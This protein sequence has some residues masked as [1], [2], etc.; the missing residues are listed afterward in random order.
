MLIET[1]PNPSSDLPYLIAEP[2]PVRDAFC[3]LAAELNVRLLSLPLATISV[4]AAA[5]CE[6]SAIAVL[7]A[8]TR[9]GHALGFLHLLQLRLARFERQPQ[10]TAAIALTSGV[11]RLTVRGYDVIM[12]TGPEGTLITSVRRRPPRRRPR[13][14]L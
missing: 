1:P 10:R 5:E 7:L 8:Q 2:R 12:R 13:R 9:R 11:V 3:V 6:L 14:A 4:T